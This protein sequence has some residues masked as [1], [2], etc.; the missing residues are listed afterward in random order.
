MLGSGAAGSMDARLAAIKAS[1]PSVARPSRPD[2]HLAGR[3]I[4]LAIVHSYRSPDASHR[5]VIRGP[6]EVAASTRSGLA[7]RGHT[8]CIAVT[9]SRPDDNPRSRPLWFPIRQVLFS[10]TMRM[11]C[12][13]GAV[14]VPKARCIPR[15]GIPV[16]RYITRDCHLRT[17]G[18]A[19][20]A[21]S[22]VVVAS[23]AEYRRKPLKSVEPLNVESIA[24]RSPDDDFGY[25][26][27]SFRFREG[28]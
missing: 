4:L 19:T 21:V 16:S 12:P 7:T 1:E 8:Q 15:V 23:R 18:P 3:T 14:P 20:F 22:L 28:I 13:F 2:F 24:L 5:I 11:P 9:V 6:S 27:I 10:A 25:Q 26:P 17:G